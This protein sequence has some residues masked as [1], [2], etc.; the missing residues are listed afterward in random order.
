MYTLIVKKKG[1]Y[2]CKHGLNEEYCSWCL[3][4]KEFAKPKKE[5]E[6]GSN[7]R[8]EIQRVDDKNNS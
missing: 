8:R 4:D 2:M 6:D 7:T 1:K 5:V 3:A